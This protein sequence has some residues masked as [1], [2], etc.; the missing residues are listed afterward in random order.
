MTVVCL[1]PNYGIEDSVKIKTKVI[2]RIRLAPAVTV[3]IIQ[4]QHSNF[5]S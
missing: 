4:S 2:R 1:Y 5:D 3:Y